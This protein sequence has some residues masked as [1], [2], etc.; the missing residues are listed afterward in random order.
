MMLSLRPIFYKVKRSTDWLQHAYEYEKYAQIKTLFT[1]NHRTHLTFYITKCFLRGIQ[2]V[3][4]LQLMGASPPETPS[5]TQTPRTWG[6]KPPRL[7]L[8]PP[9]VNSWNLPL[10]TAVAKL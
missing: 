4:R 1:R 9:S 6:A 10:V 8:A 5:C 7:P 3:L 2:T